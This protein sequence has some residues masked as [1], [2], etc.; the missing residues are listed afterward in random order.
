M[1]ITKTFTIESHNLQG[2]LINR[3]EITL[4]D[5]PAY[6]EEELKLVLANEPDVFTVSL[7]EQLFDAEGKPLLMKKEIE[8]GP[9]RFQFVERMRYTRKVG[10]DEFYRSYMDWTTK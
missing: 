5:N 6:A 9:D 4:E 8:A 10:S 1:P 7:V 3:E 2:T